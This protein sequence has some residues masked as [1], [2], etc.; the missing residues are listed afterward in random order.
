MGRTAQWWD[1]NVEAYLER[2]QGVMIE[3]RVESVLASA[4]AVFR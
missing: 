2:V 4:K 3:Q 1:L